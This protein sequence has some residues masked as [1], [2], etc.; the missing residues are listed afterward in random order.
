MNI[1]KHLAVP[2]SLGQVSP[3]G[4]K[5]GGIVRATPHPAFLLS[6]ENMAYE[7]PDFTGETVILINMPLYTPQVIQYFL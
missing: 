5:L 6:V 7:I 2:T 4:Y 3:T 1:S